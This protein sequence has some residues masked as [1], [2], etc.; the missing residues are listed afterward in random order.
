MIQDRA[1]INVMEQLVVNQPQALHLVFITREDPPLPLARLRAN[2]KLSEIRA[3]DL[4]FSEIE[5][6]RF[7]NAVVGISLSKADIYALEEKTEG[8]IVGIQLAGLT[9][10][11]KSNPSDFISNL[12]GSHRHILSYLTEQ[13]LNQQPQEIRRF[14]LQT[15]I[16]DKLNKDLCNAVTERLDAGDFLA[17][18]YNANL[19]LIP[20][21]DEQ[22]WYRYHRLFVD[23]L[24]DLQQSTQGD[25]TK[26]LHQRACQW[27]AEAGLASEAIQH[28]LSAQDYPQAVGLLEQHATPMIMQGYAKTVDSWVQTIPQEWRSQ[29]PKTNLAFA[30]AHLMRGAYAQASRYLDWLELSIADSAAREENPSLYAEWLVLKSLILYMQGEIKGC[31][32]MA[33]QALEIAPEQDSHVRSLAHYVQ[34]SVYQFRG[35]LPEAAKNYEISIRYSREAGNL[36]A[37]MMSTISLVGAAIER[38]QL[39]LAFEIASQAIDR[40]EQSDERPPVSAFIYLSLGDIYYQWYQIEEGQYTAQRALHLSNLG[41]YNTGMIFCRILLSRL[42]LARQDLNAAANEVQKAADLMPV[43]L[44]EYIRQD[45]ASQQVRVYLALDRLDAAALVLQGFGFN[46]R[47]TFSFPDLSPDQ[48][49]PFSIGMLYNSS[50]RILLNQQ[51]SVNSLNIF[52]IGLDLANRLISEHSQGQQ[53]LVVIETLLLRAQIHEKLGDPQA[54]HADMMRALE[55]AEPEGFIGVFVEQGKSVAVALAKIVQDLRPE[56]VHTEFVESIL[57]AFPESRLNDDLTLDPA[58]EKLIDPLT[59]RELD[60]LRLMVEGLK[61]KEIAAKLFVSTNTVRYHV[62][63]IYGKLNVNNRTQAIEK[64]RRLSIL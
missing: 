56:C 32:G 17:H 42:Y 28:A 21:D 43:K 35:N 25:D 27:Y 5:I 4:R 30:W 55:L 48:S 31:K 12:S 54:G 10:S 24:R 36:F 58:R 22:Q 60:V 26:Q 61:Y 3:A 51:H 15:S 53:L 16:L 2:N 1:I 6:S 18:L 49:N 39:H 11:H 57:A 63:A 47:D 64:A 41:G 7:L 44:P 34:A 9:I 52:E 38:G 13:V 50:L 62:K 19:F 14:L 37:E 59:E 23:L 45:I 46:F 40:L 33:E 29:N 20:L 8:W